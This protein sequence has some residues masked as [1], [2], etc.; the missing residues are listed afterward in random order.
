MTKVPLKDGFEYNGVWIDNPHTEE[1]G[2]FYFDTEYDAAI[3]YGFPE[4]LHALWVATE[5]ELS[6]AY[7]LY[8]NMINVFIRNADHAFYDVDM[9]TKDVWNE[10]FP[11]ED[12]QDIEEDDFVWY[13]EALMMLVR[14]DLLFKH[15]G[16]DG[17]AVVHAELMHCGE[18]Y[19]VNKVLAKE[20]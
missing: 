9:Y 12:P 1:T 13:Q 11:A 6:P 20:V 8:I 4:N 10:C 7:C 19:F 5:P 18:Q 17:L 3:Y 14:D 16:Y 15:F 2:R